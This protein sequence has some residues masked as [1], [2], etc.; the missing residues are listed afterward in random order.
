MA[1]SKVKLFTCED[2]QVKSSIQEGLISQLLIFLNNILS[3]LRIF[4]TERQ[5]E[6]VAVNMW[7][8]FVKDYSP[9]SSKG[10]LMIGKRKKEGDKYF[11]CERT[12]AD[13]A[14]SRIKEW[15]NRHLKKAFV[16]ADTIFGETF[17]QALLSQ[18]RVHRHSA[19]NK[20][21]KE[22]EWFQMG[23]LTWAN[24]EDILNNVCTFTQLIKS[25]KTIARINLN[26]ASLEK[27]QRLPL[28][29]PKIAINII[30]ARSTKLF[31]GFV[32]LNRVFKLG[33]RKINAFTDFASFSTGS[34]II[35]DPLV[36]INTASVATLLT[37]PKI[38]AVIAANI[39][40]WRKT[41]NFA[42]I[43]DLQK[44]YGI[45]IKTYDAVKHLIAV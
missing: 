9:K 34:L 7:Q 33:Q 20:K 11:F 31:S 44:V 10:F 2:G 37:L 14:E 38:G 16:C 21:K 17:A 40:K 45:G 42:N 43:S 39:D 30:S 27:L 1:K 4:M 25:T 36:N 6:I 35:E 12:F 32:D 8:K 19:C 18:I 26:T 29:G 24:I 23:S 5:V 41:K 3:V 28:V 22:V 13:K 15:K